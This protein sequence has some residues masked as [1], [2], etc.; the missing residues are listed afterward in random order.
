MYICVCIYAKVYWEMGTP[1]GQRW[2][3]NL[4]IKKN[5]DR[6]LKTSNT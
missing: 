1:T 5:N 6:K 2:E 3:K 4:G